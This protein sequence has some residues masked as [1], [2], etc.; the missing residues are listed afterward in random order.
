MKIIK[1]IHRLKIVEQ[2]IIVSIFAVLVTMTVCGFV[3]NNIN[4]HS[5]REQ[6]CNIG[7]IVA[8]SVSDSID[9]FQKSIEYE[10]TQISQNME[11]F[12]T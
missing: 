9:V 3:I 2:I 10:L 4:Q 5:V 12:P 11:Y 6:L 1:N 8:N 7:I